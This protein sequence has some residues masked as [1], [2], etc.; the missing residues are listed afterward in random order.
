MEVKAGHDAYV[1]LK[2][3][4]VHP[5]LDFNAQ[6]KLLCVTLPLEKIH[7]SMTVIYYN[8]I[9]STNSEVLTC[10]NSVTCIFHMFRQLFSSGWVLS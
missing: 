5:S 3:M 8:K 1:E 2:L 9:K 10:Y 7:P 6:R 4:C